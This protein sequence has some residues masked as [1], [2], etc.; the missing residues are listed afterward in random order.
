M[1]E[2]GERNTKAFFGFMMV[3]IVAMAF[4]SLAIHIYDRFSRNETAWHFYSPSV[5][6]TCIVARDRG[7]SV[8]SCLPGDHRVDKDGEQ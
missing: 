7:Q 8:M 4:T 1:T 3:G 6:M 5:D 2:R